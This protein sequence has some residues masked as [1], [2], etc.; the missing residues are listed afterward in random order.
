LV[1][2]GLR[3]RSMHARGN[4]ARQSGP[5]QM[6]RATVAGQQ[7]AGSRTGAVSARPGQRANNGS[8]PLAFSPL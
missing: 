3:K 5:R 4:D 1:I 2:S 6:R 7:S 8:T